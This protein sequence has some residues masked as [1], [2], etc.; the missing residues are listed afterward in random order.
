[1]RYHLFLKFFEKV[2]KIKETSLL[3][4]RCLVSIGQHCKHANRLA[5]VKITDILNC[6]S[7]QKFASN[8]SC[9]VIAKKKPF[10]F[11]KSASHGRGQNTIKPY[12]F[13]VEVA[14]D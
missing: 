6:W 8:T 10:T 5:A 13:H 14:K 2:V 7:S 12:S 3:L 1:M 4:S 9:T 11:I